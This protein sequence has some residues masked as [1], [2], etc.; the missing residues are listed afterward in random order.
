MIQHF[1]LIIRMNDCGLKSDFIKEFPLKEIIECCKRIE[2]SDL[3]KF[4]YS[5][6]YWIQ[7][8]LIRDKN[9]IK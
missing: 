5:W 9:I 2:E 8:E 3:K 4:D 1:Q 6:Y 7:E